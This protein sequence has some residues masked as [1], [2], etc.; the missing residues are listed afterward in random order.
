MAPPARDGA[1]IDGVRRPSLPSIALVAALAGCGG[2]N[3]TTPPAPSPAN[4]LVG[5]YGAPL[6]CQ[7]D[8]QGVD[9]LVGPG[10]DRPALAQADAL[11]VGRGPQGP[12]VWAGAP[13]VASGE[14][15][16]YWADAAGGGWVEGASGTAPVEMAP[17]GAR[18]VFATAGRAELRGFGLDAP[19]P[20]RGALAGACGLSLAARPGVV[21]AAGIRGGAACGPGAPWVQ[22]LGGDGLSFGPQVAL[23]LDAETAVRAVTA[24]WDF[25]R[26]V[27]RA[28]PALDGDTLAWVLDP[29]G[30]VLSTATGEVACPASGCVHVTVSQHAAVAGDA[31]MLRVEHLQHGAPWDT[32]IRAQDVAG[33]AVSGDRVLVL[34]SAQHGAVGCDLAVLHVGARSVLLEHHAEALP[35]DAGR[36]LGTP[37][38]FTFVEQEPGRAVRL[39]D[40]GCDG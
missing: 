7:L 16:V 28:T 26:F 11:R 27:V 17:L 2:R 18:V 21:L 37:R 4:E 38:G 35:C 32:G 1:T 36:V 8:A 13:S 5:S 39:R 23:P 29:D 6:R 22:R 20:L 14:L 10:V 33:L 40:I 12:R 3:Q 31:G 30:T 9:L 15:G 19:T 24:R 34:S 25:G